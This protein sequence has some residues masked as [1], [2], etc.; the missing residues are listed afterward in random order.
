[1]ERGSKFVSALMAVLA[2]QLIEPQRAPS[3]Y[4]HLVLAA[5][6][7]TIVAWAIATLGDAWNR[8][9]HRRSPGRSSL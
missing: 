5:A 4:W 1:M 8:R 6:A 2:L 7:G 3:P 9:R